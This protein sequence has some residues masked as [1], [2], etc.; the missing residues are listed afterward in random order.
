VVKKL[1]STCLESVTVKDW[2]S[3]CLELVVNKK[4]VST[5]PERVVVKSQ[6]YYGGISCGPK[7][8]FCR[9]GISH[10]EE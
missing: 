8:S 3:A 4:L 6:F 1:D 7:I 2:V 9:A 5:C 10:V